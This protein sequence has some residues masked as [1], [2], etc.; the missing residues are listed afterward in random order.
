MPS[1]NIIV[2]NHRYCSFDSFFIAFRDI[3]AKEQ[4]MCKY[5]VVITGK[6][7]KKKELV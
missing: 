1:Y 7:E 6:I 5:S 3:E 4:Q 2:A